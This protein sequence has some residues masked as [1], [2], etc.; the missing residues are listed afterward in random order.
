[1]HHVGNGSP[2]LGIWPAAHDNSA[3]E[4][5]SM[6]LSVGITIAALTLPPT[7]HEE[8]TFYTEFLWHSGSLQFNM[9]MVMLSVAGLVLSIC[10]ECAWVVLNAG[11]SQ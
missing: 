5:K 3:L 10:L 4:G 7:S 8:A 1:M 6:M 9:L 11:A 2:G